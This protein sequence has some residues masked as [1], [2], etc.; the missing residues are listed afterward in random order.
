MIR[1]LCIITNSWNCHLFLVDKKTQYTVD[2]ANNR[3]LEINNLFWTSPSKYSWKYFSNWKVFPSPL[4]R[5]HL[6]LIFIYGFLDFP[7]AAIANLYI[8]SWKS[9]FIPD[10]SYSHSLEIDMSELLYHLRYLSW[11]AS[12]P[13]KFC[14]SPHAYFWLLNQ[15]NI[16]PACKTKFFAS[17]TYSSYYRP[18]A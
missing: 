18:F 13:R 17:E 7:S 8:Y 9:A 15:A 11:I 6:F 12:K 10:L 4:L 3:F 2:P 1:F 5:L 14:H 16:V